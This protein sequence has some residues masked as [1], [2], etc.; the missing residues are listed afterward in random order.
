MQNNNQ[1]LLSVLK[2]LIGQ[3]SRLSLDITRIRLL[4]Y[5]KIF[6]SQTKVDMT[7]VLNKQVEDLAARI[8]TQK[9]DVVAINENTGQ[10]TTVSEQY[11]VAEYTN[12]VKLENVTGVESEFAKYLRQ[13]TFPSVTQP[14][15]GDALKASAWEHIH[16]A[17]RHARKGEL[18]TAKV[19]T[20]IAGTA[21]EE[22]GQFMNHED[23]SELV[24]EIEIYFTEP[25]K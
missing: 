20:A 11:S 6:N 17:I 13:K 19:H 7:S 15:L 12:E 9:I 22:A 2:K 16:C 5:R 4:S 14:H 24:C 25:L 18:D 10:L 8:V 1:N 23:Y 3:L 21:L